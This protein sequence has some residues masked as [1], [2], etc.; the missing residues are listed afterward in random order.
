MQS[1]FP[2]ST[3]DDRLQVVAQAVKLL[4]HKVDVLLG[5]GGRGHD[6][7]EEVGTTIVRLV[8]H[9]HRSALHHP[10]L[11]NGTDLRVGAENPVK[12]LPL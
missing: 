7:A 9:H 3:R 2:P 4:Q 11:D 5:H 8:A 6:G 10:G 12:I 1:W